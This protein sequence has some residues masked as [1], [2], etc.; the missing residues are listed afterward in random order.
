MPMRVSRTIV[1]KPCSLSQRMT[2]VFRPC[3]TTSR[4]HRPVLWPIVPTRQRYSPSRGAWAF[5][6]PIRK[7]FDTL[8]GRPTS[9]KGTRLPPTEGLRVLDEALT[10]VNQMEARYYEAELHRLRG[11]LLLQQSLDNQAE[12]EGCFRRALGIARHQQ[13]KS[14][15]LRAAT[16]LAQL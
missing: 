16:S 8:P 13:A 9:H 2:R 7:A 4:H 15:E 5:Q 11:A 6:M 12:A 14:F 1:R 3:A 10:Q